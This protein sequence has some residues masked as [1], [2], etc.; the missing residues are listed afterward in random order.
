LS[1]TPIAVLKPFVN[2]F[3]TA[4]NEQILPVVWNFYIHLPGTAAWL[5]N[6]VK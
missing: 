1:V 2:Y 4:D 6:K 5:F 3:D